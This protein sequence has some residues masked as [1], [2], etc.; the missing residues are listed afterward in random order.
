[1]P[2]F[3][4]EPEVEYEENILGQRSYGLTYWCEAENRNI[5]PRVIANAFYTATGI[6]IGVPF[7]W[8]HSLHPYYEIDPGAVCT[9]IRLRHK[10]EGLGQAWTVAV[11]YEP[12][13]PDRINPD[14]PTAV[15]VLIQFGAQRI[16]EDVDIDRNNR[17]V[18]NSAGEPFLKAATRPRSLESFHARRYEAS[19]NPDV[20]GLYR[21]SINDA[22]WTVR[23]R[24][25]PAK[26]MRCEA[27]QADEQY[28]NDFGIFYVVD[29][30]FAYN[31][32]GW[33][34]KILDQGLRMKSGANIIPIY[35]DGIPVTVPVLLNGSGAPL[36]EPLPVGTPPV[37]LS[38]KFFDERDFT[39]FNFPTT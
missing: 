32:D 16:E 22:A 31:P 23:G 13:D 34:P 39:A 36:P 21:D 7:K 17:P 9:S 10:A 33:Q 30:E 18:V 3:N 2:T 35:R 27:I 29:Y 6:K 5:G 19:Y 15:P 24:T 4:L 25:Y 1:M 11:Q 28:H 37:Y 8:Y 12:F 20:A 26:T 14:D 38:F